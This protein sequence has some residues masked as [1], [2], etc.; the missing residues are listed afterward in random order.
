MEDTLLAI[1][2]EFG[3]FRLEP[4][5]AGRFFVHIDGRTATQ[6]VPEGSYY[7]FVGEA[8]ESIPGGAIEIGEVYLPLVQDGT[9]QAVSEPEGTT[10]RMPGSII[11]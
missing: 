3:N 1:T 11:S 2:D 10:I 7:P 9:L 6:N 4:A 5:L 8:W